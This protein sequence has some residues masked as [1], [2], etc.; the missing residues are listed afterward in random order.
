M[1]SIRVNPVPRQA[2]SYASVA[3]G[4][5][6]AGGGDAGAG[7]SGHPSPSGSHAATPGDRTGA[8][9]ESDHILFSAGN[10]RV[11]HMVGRVHL[12]RHLPPR[13]GGGA[14]DAKQKQAAD[15]SGAGSSGEIEPEPAGEGAGLPP[16]R[17][18]Q[19]CILA[20]PADMGFA[21]LCTFMGAYFEHVREVRLVRREGRS[22]VCLVL[23][24]FESQRWADDFFSDFNGKPFCL[25]EPELLCRLVFVKDVEC[26]Q[27]AGEQRGVQQ[28]PQ[29]GPQQAPRAPP[30]T[31][32]LP[33]CPVCLERLDEHISGIVTTVC[34]H[35][36]HNECLRQ[37][38][39]TSCPVC[40]YCQHSAATTSH[41]A[42]CST[43]A[44]LWICLICG[45][46]GCG[47]YRGSHA[48]SHWQSSGHGYALELET[49]RVWDYV[50][51]TYVHRLIQSKTDGKLVEVPSP[52][53]HNQPSCSGRPLSRGPP[54]SECGSEQ[55]LMDPEME[56]AMV[57]S[58]LDALATEYNHLLVTQLE[59]QRSYFE[60]LLVRQRTEAEAE[61]EAAQ[62][63]AGEARAAAAAA[64]AAV[65]E[66]ERKR[67][68][69]ESKL[70]YTSGRLAK[71]EE[72]RQFLEQLNDTLLANQKDFQV[73]LKAAEEALQRTTAEKDAAIQDMQ[74]QV[75]DLIVFLE[76]RQTIEQAGASGE[77]EGATVLPKP[78]SRIE[79]A[80]ATPDQPPQAAQN[81]AN[82]ED[83]GD[84]GAELCTSRESLLNRGV[85]HLGLPEI[86]VFD[87]AD[88]LNASN[89]VQLF[90]GGQADVHIWPWTNTTP[91]SDASSP[92]VIANGSLVA[93]KH[94]RKPLGGGNFAEIKT[95]KEFQQA[96][97]DG[98]RALSLELNTLDALH[99]RGCGRRMIRPLGMVC[100]PGC[101]CADEASRQELWWEPT[102]GYLMPAYPRG[103]VTK[104]LGDICHCH[105][106]LPHDAAQ[107]FLSMRTLSSQFCT[108]LGELRRMHTTPGL[109]L[110]LLDL[111]ANN[112]LVDD[113]GEGMHLL[114][115][116]PATALP[117]SVV[118]QRPHQML[119]TW[120][121]GSMQVRSG[122]FDPTADLY[123]LSFVFAEMWLV[124]EGAPS[125]VH[126][127]IHLASLDTDRAQDV[128]FVRSLIAK[129]LR[130]H[131]NSGSILPRVKRHLPVS[132]LG[133]WALLLGFR[134]YQSEE[135]MSLGLPCLRPSEEEMLEVAQLWVRVC[136]AAED[137]PQDVCEEQAR[138][139][140]CQPLVG[141]MCRLL[142][143]LL[144]LSRLEAVPEVPACL[145][146]SAWL[147][148]L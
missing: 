33:T 19:L 100:W 88:S 29:Q 24:R 17:N 133:A 91:P 1:Y 76:A 2:A 106:A 63:A 50:N 43:S 21:E 28:A 135:Q 11:E 77:L 25:L 114:F 118:E 78:A 52:A 47:R 5:A 130:S 92:P 85:A 58:K 139:P 98:Q 125:P 55:C 10:P 137:L 82:P 146:A 59:S 94:L 103:S 74:E 128:R 141:D 61:V 148:A 93:L 41:C 105:R 122:R 35:R 64:Q 136:A 51:D 32:E 108:L 87:L 38:G 14:A 144:Q 95:E 68:Q 107:R 49:Q 112:L 75:R 73:R 104:L 20:L 138:S 89:N 44:D 81:G 113:G 143:R 62:A 4:L 12:Y 67:R 110:Q 119:G 79:P 71:A 30:G 45:H 7:G 27:A 66:A 40:R 101:Y 56:E 142:S 123:S 22:S 6:G 121:W 57:L 18:E 129:V 42:V 39:D 34:N 72:E 140:A 131:H 69:A 83:G 116:D 124:A 120:L 31:T 97:L 3:A 86:D 109:R 36:F 99:K 126:E 26:Q 53:Q 37:W 115:A 90:G 9:P 80:Q 65:Q 134:D 60:G 84:A 23:L 132:W 15:S 8:E 117:I 70:A 54:A 102:Y 96:V 16:G 13:G 111:T 46:V 145:P 127:L 48:A 147:P